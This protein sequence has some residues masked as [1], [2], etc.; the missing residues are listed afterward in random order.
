LTAALG[1]LALV[2]FQGCGGDTNGGGGDGGNGS[3]G[4]SKTDT[5]DG[6]G[7][8]TY[9]DFPATARCPSERVVGERSDFEIRFTNNSGQPW[10][11]TIFGKKGDDHFVKHGVT[12]Q[13]G[14]RGIPLQ[15]GT[16]NIDFGRTPAG[17]RRTITASETPK[18]AGNFKVELT[19]W[20][21]DDKSDLPDSFPAVTCSVAV[22]P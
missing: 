20:G 8:K 18:D 13:N 3:D 12:D 9:T 4:G 5:N 15:D 1:V 10:K 19:I 11:H 2:A 7:D 22:D 14:R 6:G 16:G 21:A 17:A